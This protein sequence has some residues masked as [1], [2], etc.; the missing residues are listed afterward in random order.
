MASLGQILHVEYALHIAISPRITRFL[1]QRVDLASFC[2]LLHYILFEVA[3]F[4]LL[5]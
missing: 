4:S 2:D 3:L 5:A 1:S